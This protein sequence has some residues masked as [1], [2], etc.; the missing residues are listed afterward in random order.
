MFWIAAHTPSLSSATPGSCPSPQSISWKGPPSS[1]P[2]SWLS[3]LGPPRLQIDSSLHEHPTRMS[4]FCPFN[5]GYKT[6]WH[7]LI[8]TVTINST[9]FAK[10]P[11]TFHSSYTQQH[12]I[13]FLL[14]GYKIHIATRC[15]FNQPKISQIYGDCYI[16]IHVG[17]SC[18]LSAYGE[19]SLT[20]FL[21]EQ[22]LTLK[23]W[24]W[25]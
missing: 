20:W 14:T 13:G 6:T 10:S 17:N 12:M 8:Y 1:G 9:Q 11:R 19:G 25:S 5:L 3:P 16:G 21:F 18:N 22:V 2:Q 24:M 7:V 15:C 23:W 4:I